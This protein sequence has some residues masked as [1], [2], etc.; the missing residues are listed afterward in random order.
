MELYDV[1]QEIKTK[2]DFEQFLLLLILDLKN[3]NSEWENTDLDRY[4][5]AMSDYT[6]TLNE[7]DKDGNVLP[8]NQPSWKLF[9]E[10]LMAARVYE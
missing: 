4:L 10:L 3:K 7:T 8:D 9:A 6:D 1:L 2:E 5:S